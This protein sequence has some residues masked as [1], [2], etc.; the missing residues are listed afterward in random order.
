M[1][2][3]LNGKYFNAM[4]GLQRRKSVVLDVSVSDD[5]KY[6]IK[7]L[8]GSDLFEIEKKIIIKKKYPIRMDKKRREIVF[9]PVAKT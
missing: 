1:R 6:I 4:K 9:C 3:K 7:K 2:I 8:K 5:M